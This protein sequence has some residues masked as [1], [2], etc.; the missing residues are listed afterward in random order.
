MTRP[1][2]RLDDRALVHHV[3]RGDPAAF[4]ALFRRHRPALL[5][6]AERMLA[7]R[8]PGPEDVVQ[9][10]FVRAHAA[11]L[12]EVLDAVAGLPPRQRHALLSGPVH[13][14]PVR[15]T[16]AELGISEGATKNLAHRARASLHAQL[17]G[18]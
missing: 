1:Y 16:A 2:D 12:R 8:S 5:R 11:L 7:G 18:A 3:R 4:E 15:C 10:V 13:G 9:D 17:A 14:R 6:A